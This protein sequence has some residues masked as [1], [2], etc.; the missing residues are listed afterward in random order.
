RL[1]G[2]LMPFLRPYAWRIA[3]AMLLLLATTGLA[4]VQPLLVQQA[5]DRDISKGTTDDLWWIIG[6]YILVLVL[7]FVF[8]Y[9]QALQMVIVAQKVMNDLRMK[10]FRHL[11]RMSIAFYDANPVGRLVTRLNHDIAAPGYVVTDG[12]GV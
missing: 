5:I 2:R 3:L 12:G 8:R 9:V 11:Q 4:L 7:M 10:L 6:A 1:V